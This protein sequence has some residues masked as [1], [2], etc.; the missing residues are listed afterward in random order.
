MVLASRLRPLPSCLAVLVCAL[1]AGP[2][3]PHGGVGGG[4]GGEGGGG[5]GLAA[6]KVV[7]G[8]SAS[9]V[10]PSQGRGTAKPVYKTKLS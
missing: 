10:T 6:A 5:G 9:G 3:L 8:T 1:L 7:L 4:G 2:M